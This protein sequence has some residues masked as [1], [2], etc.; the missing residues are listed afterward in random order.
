MLE[1]PRAAAWAGHSPKLAAFA[2]LEGPLDLL[3]RFARRGSPDQY[4][5][6][7]IHCLGEFSQSFLHRLAGDG[8]AFARD[9]QHHFGGGQP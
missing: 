1:K 3:T 2:A 8:F 9:F 5:P 4:L 6:S 7:P